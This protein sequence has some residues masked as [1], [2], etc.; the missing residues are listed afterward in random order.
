M[1]GIGAPMHS[2]EELHVFGL[3]I[4]NA[5]PMV[6]S[7]Q[8]ATEIANTVA[9]AINCLSEVAR[10]TNTQNTVRVYVPTGMTDIERRAVEAKLRRVVAEAVGLSTYQVRAHKVSFAAWVTHEEETDSVTYSH[11]P[12]LVVR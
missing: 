4:R 12:S 11:F 6:L 5:T 1:S 2:L 9:A 7:S 10:A 8:R 3:F